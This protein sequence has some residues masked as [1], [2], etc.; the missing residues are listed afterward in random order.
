MP[1]VSGVLSSGSAPGR[2]SWANVSLTGSD[3]SSEGPP[4]P[5]ASVLPAADCAVATGFAGAFLAAAALRLEPRVDAASPRLE[6]R[7]EIAVERLELRVEAV[8][9][10][11]RLEPRDEPRVG[12]S[13]FSGIPSAAPAGLSAFHPSFWC[14]QCSH[15]A[16]TTAVRSR[17]CVALAISGCASQPLHRMQRFNH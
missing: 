13:V 15:R 2:S 6:P 9:P 16:M 5:H 11:P 1:S 14:A 4:M 7:V 10:V 17:L 8:A 3:G 12:C